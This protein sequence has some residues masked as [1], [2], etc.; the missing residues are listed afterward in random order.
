[1]TRLIYSLMLVAALVLSMAAEAVAQ[2]FSVAS[3]RM[4]AN[5]VTAFVDPVNDLNDEACGLIKVMAGEDFVFSTPLGIVKRV[6]KVGEIWLYVPKGTKKLTIK[7]ADWGVLRDYA[8]SPKIDSHVSYEL[9]ITEPL[10]VIRQ[11]EPERIV[12]T[13][14]D[15]LVVTRVD[16]LVLETPRKLVP[17]EFDAL[18]TLGYGGR[19]KTMSG[20]VMAVAMKRHGAFVHVSTDF[21]RIGSTVG[22]CDKTGM[23]GGVKPFYTGRSRHS[24][25]MINAGAAHRLSDRVAVFEGLGYASSAIAWQLASSEG[26]GYI[27]NKHYSTAGLSFEV[28]AI[29]K[30]GRL[31]LSASVVS[32]KGKDWYGSAGIG[33]VIG[34]GR[35]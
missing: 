1:M 34:K 15:T 25:F 23:T 12:T 13:V 27:K 35:K 10:A 32:I 4:L 16:T 17:F 3:F 24:A 31:R 5:D 7:H 2:R 19:S 11:A 33:L 28:G 22:E 9:R 21:G 8:L 20:G 29:L 26:G 18:V 30:F 6:D 14:V